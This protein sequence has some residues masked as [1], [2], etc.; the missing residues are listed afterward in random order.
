MRANSC[1]L[2][3]VVCPCLVT[4]LSRTWKRCSE[5]TAPLVSVPGSASPPLH[6]PKLHA[7]KNKPRQECT[8]RSRLDFLPLVTSLFFSLSLL[9]FSHYVSVLCNLCSSRAQNS[10]GKVS[11]VTPTR[12]R[13]AYL[14]LHGKK[15]PKH[16]R[17]RLFSDVRN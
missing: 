11:C 14:A 6:D 10:S 17:P 8:L 7:S 5:L 2:P 1:S 13:N 12:T 15:L 16:E 9:F 4:R 3:R